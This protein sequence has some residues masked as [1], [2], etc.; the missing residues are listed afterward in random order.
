MNRVK[1]LER[2]YA[3]IARLEEKV[4]PK[5]AVKLRA[6]F[7]SQTAR[8][9]DHHQKALGWGRG[10]RRNFKRQVVKG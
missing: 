8:F 10:Q 6:R 3:R 2:A 7:D 9:I 4:D 1:R 5:V